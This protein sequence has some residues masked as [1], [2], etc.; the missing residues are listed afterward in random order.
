MTALSQ[1]SSVSHEIDLIW[2][3]VPE[4]WHLKNCGSLIHVPVTQFKS[5]RKI[6]RRFS[7]HGTKDVPPVEEMWSIVEDGDNPLPIPGITLPDLPC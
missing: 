1:F 4:N 2:W 7:S 6:M 3:N 5:V